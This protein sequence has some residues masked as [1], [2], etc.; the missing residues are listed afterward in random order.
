[1]VGLPHPTRRKKEG[2]NNLGRK[3]LE[4]LRKKQHSRLCSGI[5]YSANLLIFFVDFLSHIIYWYKISSSVSAT[6]RL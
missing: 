4:E 6:S 1:M 3:H 5:M 2:T